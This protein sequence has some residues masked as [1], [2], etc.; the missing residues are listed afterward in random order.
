MTTQQTRARLRPVLTNLATVADGVREDQRSESTPCAEYDV[1]TLTGHIVGWLENFAGGF[2]AADG[3][4]PQ[5]DVTGVQVSRDEAEPRIR[6]AAESLDASLADGAAERDLVIE[7]QGGMPGEMALSMMLAEYII[8]GWDLAVATGQDWSADDRAVAD[9]L[10]FLQ[11]MVTPESRGPGGMFG[12]EVEVA[13]DAPVLDRLV[14]FAGR[15]PQWK[16]PR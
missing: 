11:G 9:S 7:G 6:R 10:T 3:Q 12:E 5:A 8:H 1:A 2:A 15:D 16:A 4:C 13:E 14:G